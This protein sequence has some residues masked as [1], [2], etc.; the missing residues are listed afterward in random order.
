[1]TLNDVEKLQAKEMA[2][3]VINEMRQ[4]FVT[5]KQAYLWAITFMAAMSVFLFKNPHL[6][7]CL[8]GKH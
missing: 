6:V 2:R 5:K 1:M 3:E 7:S 8:V 4:Y